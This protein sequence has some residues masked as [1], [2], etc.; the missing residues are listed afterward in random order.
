METKSKNGEMNES[1]TMFHLFTSRKLELSLNSENTNLLGF[2]GNTMVFETS[3][4]D[5]DKSENIVEYNE[6][7]NVSNKE[8]HDKKFL[9]LNG[10]KFQIIKPKVKTKLIGKPNILKRAKLSSASLPNEVTANINKR[11]GAIRK[12]LPK[13][14]SDTDKCTSVILKS[15][16]A[17][18]NL[19]KNT[20][21]APTSVIKV[22]PDICI[23][24]NK[25]NAKSEILIK[26]RNICTVQ[27]SHIAINKTVTDSQ[28]NIILN[29]SPNVQIENQIALGGTFKLVNSTNMDSRSIPLKSNPLSKTSKSDKQFNAKTSLLLVPGPDAKG[30]VKSC[31][32]N[33]N[34]ILVSTST[35]T[36]DVTVISREVQTEEPFDYLVDSLLNECLHAEKSESV[37]TGRNVN[38]GVGPSSISVENTAKTRFFC[39]L[40]NCLVWDS[41][42]LLIHKGVIQRDLGLVKRQ[43]VMLKARNAGVNIMNNSN[44]TPLQLAVIHNVNIEIIQLLLSYKADMSIL[45][46]EGNNVLHLAVENNRKDLVKLFLDN[47][48]NSS[49][50]IDQ[51]NYNGLTPL[52][53]CAF[54]VDRIDM[55]E[56]LLKM[57][58]QPNL[59]DLKSG[60]TVLFH[61]AENHNTPIVSL[62]LDYSAD[63]KIRNFFGTSIHD[64]VFELDDIPNEIKY[65]ILGRDIKLHQRRRLN[66]QDGTTNSDQLKRKK[67]QIVPTYQKIMSNTKFVVNMAI[68]KN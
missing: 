41:G 32:C 62:L 22:N 18:Q 55:A 66:L 29:S 5:K 31:D 38:M 56:N 21:A 4:S 20:S 59:R 40:K 47:I 19:S 26:D 54:D 49:M 24:E 48:H 13:V 65:P 58:A 50:D 34:K 46:P 52:M 57:G 42:N 67:L 64:A 27:G 3:S 51:F 68:N 9:V 39:D 53:L 10:K 14:L 33:L 7:V 28:G 11:M 12:I 43:C 37:I 60:R 8:S 6:I 61:G 1:N 63:T 17:E 44:F 35:S 2:K 25:S 30:N 45:D 23:L 15:V 36:E 16:S